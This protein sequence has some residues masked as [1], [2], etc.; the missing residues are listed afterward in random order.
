MKAISL[1][2]LLMISACAN[3]TEIHVWG[4]S[5]SGLDNS[6]P[7]VLMKIDADPNTEGH[8][9]FPI[10]IKNHAQGGLSYANQDAE[11]VFK[12]PEWTFCASNERQSKR[13]VTILWLG[14][15]DGLFG[16]DLAAVEHSVSEAVRFF[17]ENNCELHVALPPER[18]MTS[19]D[20]QSWENVR[21]VIRSVT[22]SYGLEPVEV[23]YV[24]AW[25]TDGLHP[26]DFQ[27]WALANFWIREIL[28]ND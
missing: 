24:W 15:N 22:E 26:N 14:G 3:S 1:A 18:E 2:L 28:G 6:W 8:Q 9:Q 21:A 13:R 12:V 27:S 11:T 25:T 19:P 5:L 23:P 17:V 10:T 4:D 20:Y 16:S 7:N